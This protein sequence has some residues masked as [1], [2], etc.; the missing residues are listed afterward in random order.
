MDDRLTRASGGADDRPKVLRRFGNLKKERGD[1][2]ALLDKANGRV[3][4]E[5][6]VY[7]FY[8]HSAKAYA[9]QSLT[10]E[11]VERLAALQ[12]GEP[13]NGWFSRIVA[14]GTGRTFELEDNDRWLEI[15]RPMIEAFLHARYFL[16]MAVK[17]GRERE[18]PPQFMPCGWAAL[19]CLYNL[20]HGN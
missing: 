12:P 15:T 8:H 19:L 18:A 2:A 17:H 5:N 3:W 9:L 4:Y 16:E 14:D 13:L 7:R 6:L 20:R 10:L 11:I 1:L